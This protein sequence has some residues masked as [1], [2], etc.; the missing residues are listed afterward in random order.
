MTEGKSK[1]VKGKIMK[2]FALFLILIWSLQV[3]GQQ[4]VG[5]INGEVTDPNGAVIPNAKV[6]AIPIIDNKLVEEKSLVTT[7][8]D[9]GEF[10]F[11]NVA[12]GLYEVQVTVSW[13]EIVI[14]KRINVTNDKSA[15]TNLSFTKYLIEACADVSE[16][17]DLTTEKDKAEIV[18]EILQG[19]KIDEKPKPI[20]STKNIRAEWLENDDRQKF[21]LMRQADIQYQADTRTDFEYY[22]FSIFRVKGTCVEISFDYIWAVGKNSQMVYLSGNGS[23]YEFRKGDGKWIKRH[24]FSWVS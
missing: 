13:V 21:K 1:K 22:K 16:I 24:V 4:R 6:K 14:K 15:Q 9:N 12:L 3:F 20:L 17:K 5:S 18:R 23:T 2:K 7:T 8:K 10:S 19:A 11:Q